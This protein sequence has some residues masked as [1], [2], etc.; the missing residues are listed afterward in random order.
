VPRARH[1]LRAAILLSA[2]LATPAT[3]HATQSVRLQATLTPE[4][5]GQATTVGFG[6]QIAAPPRQVPSPLTE[7]DVRYP[8]NLGIALSGLGLATCSPTTLQAFGPK[9]CPANS[10]LGYGTAIA[11]IQIGPEIER[12]TT[13]IT[14]IRAPT[15]NGRFALLF[16]VNGKDPISAQLVFP[17][18]LLPTSP[19]FG[20]RINISVPL[21]PSLPQAPD[22]AVIKLTTTLGPEHLTYYEHTHNGHTIAYNPKG[23]LLPNN[24]P[25]NGFPFTA[26]FGF[27]DGTHTNAHTTIPCPKHGR[28]HH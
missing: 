11:E 22:V 26:T 8:G 27:Q 5:L 1:L 3:A 19:P 25:H 16:Y 21:V 23:I 7:V 6:F 20:G 2:C 24:C 4:R 9:G 28:G 18:L 13:N 10:L 17:G 15:Q 12:E 14:L